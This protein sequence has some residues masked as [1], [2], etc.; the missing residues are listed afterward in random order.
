[1]EV[2]ASFF[3]RLSPSKRAL[4]IIGLL[5][6]V[7]A[8]LS[9]E[10]VQMVR[11]AFNFGAEAHEGQSRSSGEAYISHPVAVA[12]ILA[13][14]NFDVQTLVAAILHDTIEDTPVEQEHIEEKFGEEVALL[15]EGVTKLDKLKF[16]TR[17]EAQAESFRKLM[18]AMTDDIR[19][20]LIKLADRA[21]H[22]KH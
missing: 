12:S 14:M 21:L 2:R 5:D 11:D 7:R 1:M 4:G 6:Q 19:V 13:E 20:I 22:A 3:D 8:Y 17:E 16:R 15:V 18:L 9:K 10:D